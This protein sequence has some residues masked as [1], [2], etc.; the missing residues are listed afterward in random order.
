MHNRKLEATM[1]QAP[2]VLAMSCSWASQGLSKVKPQ[3][4]L[5]SAGVNHKCHKSAHVMLP[6]LW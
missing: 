6:F 3:L 4:Q 5:A 2:S 1:P